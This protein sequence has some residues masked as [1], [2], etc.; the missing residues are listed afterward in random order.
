VCDADA[1]LLAVLDTDVY[2]DP[3]GRRVARVHA[4]LLN[5]G[6]LILLN[7]QMAF[8]TSDQTHPVFRA[9]LDDLMWNR[10]L[11]FAAQDARDGEVQ[12]RSHSLVGLA[13][14]TDAQLWRMLTSVVS[15]LDDVYTRV[16]DLLGTANVHPPLA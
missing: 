3:S 11:V 13:G 14:P 12:F 15:A 10:K 16:A 7:S 8:Q 6:A 9:V 5:D 4:Q 1:S 2:R